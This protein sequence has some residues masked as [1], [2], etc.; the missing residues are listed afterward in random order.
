MSTVDLRPEGSGERP[1]HGWRRSAALGLILAACLALAFFY[2]TGDDEPPLQ[3][4][5]AATSP[6]GQTPSASASAPT[7]ARRGVV[8]LA[9]GDSLSRGVQPDGTRSLKYGYPRVLEKRLIEQI[10]PAPILVEAGCG[11]ATT[12]SMIAGG[13]D[14]EPDAPIPYANENR[15]S[16]QLIWAVKQLEARKDLPTLVTLTV[17]GNDITP[18]TSPSVQKVESCLEEVIPVLKK[19]WTVIA[20]RLQAAA[21][22]KTVLA[23]AT[24]YDP[25]LGYIRLEGG[26]NADAAKAFHRLIVRRV[27]PIMRRVFAKYD[28]KI[29]DVA[30]AMHEKGSIDDR[31][32]RAVSAVCTLTWA[33]GNF[34]V[35]LNDEGYALAADVFEA[36]VIDPVLAAS[37]TKAPAG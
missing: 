33:C 26:K 19:N 6:G 21:G 10:K 12:E 36:A 5:V 32:G 34:D 30:D 4:P 22:P 17:G 28:W 2:F 37:G 24:T 27:N 3:P 35:H 8:Y 7:D 9:L 16:S 23:V 25:I 31:D 29:A 13:K 15:A 1:W 11:G 14:C 20:R 18:C